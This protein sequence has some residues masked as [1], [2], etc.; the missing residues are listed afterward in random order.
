MAEIGQARRLARLE[1]GAS[2]HHQGVVLE[3][4]PAGQD[5]PVAVDVDVVDLGLDEPD[6]GMQLGT[7]RAHDLVHR[8]QAEGDEEQAGLVHVAVVTIDH[9]DVCR[10]TGERLAEPVRHQ[11]P[12]GAAAEDDDALCHTAIVRRQGGAR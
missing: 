10:L 11:R 12:A 3:N 9:H 4:G 6:P 1:D 8:R 2:R 7:A 5:H